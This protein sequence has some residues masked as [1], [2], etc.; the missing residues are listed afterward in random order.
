ME[1]SFNRDTLSI[2]LDA[3]VHGPSGKQRVTMVLDTG[4]SNCMISQNVAMKI[5]YDNFEGS[6]FIDVQSASGFIRSPKIMV[7]GMDVFGSIVKDIDVI[8]H[9]LP[10][11]TFVDGL[12]GLNFLKHFRLTLDFPNG[13]LIM[14]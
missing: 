5:G 4:A 3:V 11:G 7:E 6:E 14:E 9:D 8:V 2:I 10:K 1:L 13:K 12:I